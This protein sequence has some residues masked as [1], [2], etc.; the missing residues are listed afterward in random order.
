M[1]QENKA[2]QIFRKTNISYPLMGVRNVRFSE[3]LACFVFVK[4]PFWDSPFCLITDALVLDVPFPVPSLDNWIILAF[5]AYKL[6]RKLPENIWFPSQKAIFFRSDPQCFGPLAK[7]Q[8]NVEISIKTARV[9][10]LSFRFLWLW[11][12]FDT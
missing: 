4:H 3:N 10:R 5:V 2:R 9:F 8:H 11:L 6:A 7:F 1:F 12:H